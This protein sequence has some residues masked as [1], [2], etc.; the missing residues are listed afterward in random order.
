MKF[1]S[2]YLVIICLIVTN[3]TKSFAQT[4][5][6]PPQLISL[7]VSPQNVNVTS[8]AALVTFTMEVTD[9]LS[10]VYY[11]YP[12]ITL[13]NGYTQVLPATLVSGNALHGVW[14]S[15]FSVPQYSAPGVATFS[16]TLCDSISICADFSAADLL[17][18]GF[19]SD[20]QIINT[21]LDVNPP[22]LTSLTVSPP[23]IDVN[24]STKIATFTIQANDNLS[25]VQSILPT[26]TFPNGD[27][28]SLYADLIAGNVLNGTW[29]VTFPIP[30]YSQPGIVTFSL[31]VCD[32]NSNCV[33]FYTAD[34]MAAGFDYEFEIVNAQVDVSPPQLTSLVISPSTVNVSPSAEMVTF[35][36]QANDD[37]SGIQYVFSGINL[38][39][40]NSQ[41]FNA[42][43]ISGTVLNGTWQGTF[44]VPQYSQPGIASVSLSL[45]DSLANCITYY[46]ADLMT[47]GF[48]HEFEITNLPLPVELIGFS[49]KAKKEGIELSW[50][51][52]SE[53]NNGGF[54]VDYSVDARTWNTIGFVKGKGT[55]LQS[56]DY[57]YIHTNPE[58][59]NNYYRLKQIDL[60]GK[61]E[62]SSVINVEIPDDDNIKVYP[63]PTNGILKITGK[64]IDHVSIKVMDVL[65]RVVKDA[66]FYQDQ[67]DL[68][69]LPKGCYFLI[70]NIN[71]EIL[72]QQ[73]IKR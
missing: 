32:S 60:D 46:N 42:S 28:Q 54:E 10:G 43:L 5:N 14:E 24:T 45:C 1:A 4:D 37:L 68:S 29:Q 70:M 12:T 11:V 73:I 35:T 22:Q 16:L 39:N 27:M 23:I 69:N 62:Y 57:K 6:L 30:R 61:F 19:D 26:I 59:G 56:N 47:N 51:T 44:T 36:I 31:V 25:G 20:L 13:P 48:D 52:A 15:T 38:P 63:N 18:D 55:S 7:T 64:G 17:A 67:L 3:Y 49:G 41:S 50:I 53:S 58:S 40:G 33:S 8:T 71:G 2:S 66:A 21:Q 34:L 65:G 9:N 72:E